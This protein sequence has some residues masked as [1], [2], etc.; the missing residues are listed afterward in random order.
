MLTDITST[1]Y[2]GVYICGGASVA[3]VSQSGGATYVT[4]TT[5]PAAGKFCVAFN[6]GNGVYSIY[7]NYGNSIT[8]NVALIATKASA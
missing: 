6:S 5:T 8:F 3:L 4:P 7:N 2:T 1:G